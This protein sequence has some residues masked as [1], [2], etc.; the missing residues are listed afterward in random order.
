MPSHELID[1]VLERCID[2]N[3]VGSQYPGMTYEQGVLAGI[4]WVLGHIDEIP[5]EDM[6]PDQGESK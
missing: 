1:K 4:E 5:F 2:S 3:N 6:E